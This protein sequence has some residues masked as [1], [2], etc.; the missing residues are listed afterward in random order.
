MEDWLPRLVE[1]DR[2]L[3]QW[4]RTVAAELAK[5]K[6][7][8]RLGGLLRRPRP[9]ELESAAVEARRRAGPEILAEVAALFDAL[10]D[11]LLVALPQERA[12]IRAKIGDHQALWELFWSYVESAPARLRRPSDAAELD[13][14]LAA[15]A[16][17]DLRH[18][19]ELVDQVTGRIV[20]AAAAAGIDWRAALARVAAVANRSTS[21]GASHMSD[22]LAGFERSKHFT[23]HVADDVRSASRRAQDNFADPGFRAGAVA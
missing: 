22:Y 23:E 10:C 14:A 13:R 15:V 5:L 18:D 1:L 19:L 12:K 21:G 2:R 3:E 11:R 8:R 9:A 20:I 4:N 16:I 6:R 17:D 7:E